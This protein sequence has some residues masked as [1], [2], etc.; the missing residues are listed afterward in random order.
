[1]PVPPGA[2]HFKVSMDPAEI[3]DYEIKLRDLDDPLLAEDEDIASYTLTLYPEAVALGL[4][5]KTGG[6]YDPS[7]TVDTIKIW[8]D[9][10]AGEQLNAEYDGAGAELAMELTVNTTSVPARKRQRTIILTVVQ[11]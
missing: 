3:L 8:F 6:G 7:N 5:I 11:L 9:V 10:D 1:M 2:F 4:N